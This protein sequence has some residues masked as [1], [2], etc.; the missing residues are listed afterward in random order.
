MPVAHDIRGAVFKNASAVLMARI[1]GFD[2]QPITTSDIATVQYSVFEVDP[3]DYNVLT[4]VTG[5][6]KVELNVAAVFYDTLQAGGPWALDAVGY[7][8]LHQLDVSTS[9][10]FPQA[11]VRYLVRYEVIPTSG[12]KIVFRFLVTCL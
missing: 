9:E 4:P 8:F 5:H 7:N 1:V 2:N 10:A 6:D 11:G 12:Q 3:C